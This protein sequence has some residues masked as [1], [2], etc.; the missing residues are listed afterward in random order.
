[1]SERRALPVALPVTWRASPNHGERRNGVKADILV[2]HY[3]ATPTAQVALDWLCMP[4]KEVSAHYLVDEAGG[5]V[6]MVGEDRRA[7]HAGRA[8]WK[9]ETDINSRSIGI[10]IQNEGPEG[11]YPDFPD[12]QM[13]TVEALCRDILTRHDIPPERVLAHSDV[14]PGRKIDP[15]E[16]FDWARLHRAGIGHWVA[17]GDIGDGPVLQMGD[18]GEGVAELRTKLGAYGYNIEPDE[19]YD[20]WTSTI[21]S[22]FQL[23]FRQ[24]RADGIADAST[25]DTLDRLLL[26]LGT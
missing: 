4:E 25:V 20:G 2:L 15:G 6:Q 16:K 3:T 13:A 26:G 14:A 24:A 23:H 7:W 17:P 11:D 21:V 22:A 18:K 9:G 19:L 5:V 10:E 1:M 8:S 12:R